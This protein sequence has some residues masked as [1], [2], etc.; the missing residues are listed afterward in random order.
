MLCASPVDDVLLG[1]PTDHSIAISVLS[2]ENLQLFC[3]YGTQSGVYAGRT[4][5]AAAAANTP[6]VLTL[7]SLA[8]DTQYFYRIRYRSPGSSDFLAGIERTFHTQRASGSSFTFDI[9]AD[10]HYLDYDPDVY[11][12][13]LANMLADKPDFLIDLG[14]TFMTEKWEATTYTQA[15]EYCRAM[16]SGFFS[17]LGHSIPL[18]LVNGNHEGELGWLLDDVHPHGN[19]AVWSTQARQLYYPCPIPGSFYSG[20]TSLDP[21]LLSQRD[22]YYAFQWGNALFIVL[23][24]FWYTTTK[25]LDGWSWTLGPEQYQWLQRTLAQSTAAIKFV[26]VHHLVGGSLDGIARGGVEFAKYFEW[27]GSNADG[28]PGFAAKRPGWAMPIQNLLLNYGVQIVFHGHDHFFARQD[29]D[30]NGDGKAEL[31]YQECPRPDLRDDS[32]PP[33]GRFGYVAGDIRGNSGHLRVHVTPHKATVEYVRAYHPADQSVTQVNGTVEYSYSMPSGPVITSSFDGNIVLGRPTSSSVTASVLASSAC[34]A[35]VEY[36]T[37]S[38]VYPNET[39]AVTLTANQPVEQILTSLQADTLYYYRLRFRTSAGSE[40]LAG[41]EHTFRTQRAPGSTFTFVVQSDSHLY[42]RKCTPALYQ[43]A[44]K[45]E[46]KDAPDFLLDLGDTFGDDHDLTIGYPA[47]LQ[48]HLDQRPYLGDVAGSAPLFLV[49]GNHEAEGGYYLNGTPDNLAIYGTLAR[50]LYY[51]NPVPDGFYSGN[52]NAEPFVGLPANYYA[53]EWGDALFVVLDAYRHMTLDPKVTGDLWDWTL[54]KTQYDWLKATLEGSSARYKFVFAHHV[55]GQTRGA[56][57]WAGKYEW[58]GYEGN[59]TTWGFD[60]RRPGWAKPIHQLMVDN[61]VTIFFQGHDHLYAREE[62]DGVVYQE[63]PMPSDATYNVGSENASSYTG[64]VLTNSGHLRVTVSP[65][66]VKVDYVRAFLPADETAGQTNGMVAHSYTIGESTST[67]TG[68]VPDTGQTQSYTT[69][70]GE[71]ADYTINPPSYTDNKDGTV[72]DNVTGLMWQQTDG[73]EMTWE[74][75]AAYATTLS[76]GGHDDWRLP[77]SHEAFGIL[78]QGRLNPAMDTTVFPASAAQYWWTADVRAGDSSRVWVTNAGG[79]IG[80]HLKTETISAGGSKRYHV[81][82]VRGGTPSSGTSPIHRLVDNSDGTITDQD[83]GLMWQQAETA[84]PMTWEAALRYAEGLSLSR[85]RDWRLPNIKEL[86]SINDE[87]LS[88]PSLDT[89]YFTGAT[90]SR[91]WS[92]TSQC[93]GVN[94]AWYVDFQYGLVSYVDKA[95]LLPVRCVRGGFQPGDFDRDGDVDKDDLL[96]VL[97]CVSGPTIPYTPGC[98]D[99]DLD[100]DGDV[101][102]TDFGVF[103]RCIS[104]SGIAAD[105]S[106]AD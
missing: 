101:D 17:L 41:E 6:L 71:D 18:F 4:S 106:C 96:L 32:M 85:Y 20:A 31:A 87:T 52:T 24:P 35:F 8:A 84:S 78:N 49:L 55:L 98:A 74:N 7:D 21:Y 45:N 81:R 77:T 66:S 65:K 86:Q 79:G 36:G 3:E 83:T 5:E 105:S 99:R 12:V 95:T 50:Q 43:I 67:P 61:Q 91:Y 69:T 15:A 16:R 88:K 75:A 47:M 26:F 27:G 2:T 102:Q 68:G 60:T 44:L 37:Q 33:S 34:D 70:F 82:S 23:D 72:T 48:L 64:D 14:D 97:A 40:F 1:R 9:E 28:T 56:A 11:K 80:P 94:S 92:S 59:G 38:G 104:G 100:H 46:L 13:T 89:R 57:V 30:A 54:G 76:L 25:P 39:S 42:D 103:Q 22:G 90:A 73:G 53:W 29:Y 62:L 63:V 19:L 10:P 93:N 51:P 58:G